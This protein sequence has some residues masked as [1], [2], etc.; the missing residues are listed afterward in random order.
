[1]LWVMR[2]RTRIEGGCVLLCSVLRIGVA[3]L[4]CALS[5]AGLAQSAGRNYAIDPPPGSP[6][7]GELMD[8]QA[9]GAVRPRSPGAHPA[10][11]K[12]TPEKPLAPAQA[13]VRPGA[14]IRPNPLESTRSWLSEIKPPVRGAI[15]SPEAASMPAGRIAARTMPT[16]PSSTLANA[17][18]PTVSPMRLRSAVSG[19]DNAGLITGTIGEAAS[20]KPAS[21]AAKPHSTSINQTTRPAPAMA[22]AQGKPANGFGAVESRAQPTMPVLP[23]S[24]A[25]KE[26]SKPAAAAAAAPTAEAVKAEAATLP[27][28]KPTALEAD[29]AAAPTA[30]ANGNKAEPGFVFV[31]DQ[32]L[33]AF[34]Q[35]FARRYGLR[36]D[37]ASGIRGKLTQVKLPSQPRELLR[38]LATRYEIEWTFEGEVLKVS[39]RS[40]MGTRVLPLGN[41]AFNDWI[42]EL[43]AAGLDTSRYTPIPM[44]GSKAAILTAPVTYLARAAA[45]LEVLKTGREASSELRIIRAGV[46]QKV[47]F[48]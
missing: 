29:A 11:P 20:R 6:T 35:D 48:D 25:P 10:T 21:E 15:V 8:R 46:S 19:Q 7:I 37:I 2:C 34:L 38:E 16:S 31:V 4:A 44:Q 5:G 23:A 12:I 27:P 17:P 1:M 36:A 13:V 22:Q 18:L 45:I 9:A 26:K 28:G 43:N 30:A 40:E 41:V 32:D 24:P 42:S 14:A 3:V 39:S 47:Q 33:R